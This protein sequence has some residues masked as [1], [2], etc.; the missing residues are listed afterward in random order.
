MDGNKTCQTVANSNTGKR[1]KRKT[2]LKFSEGSLEEYESFKSQFIVHHKMLDW[3]TNRAG[4]ELYVSL[5]GKAALN[6]EEVA[7]NA[8]STS[9]LSG[10]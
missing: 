1:Y 5:Q 6:V 10:M 2:D 4:I 3:D 8:K 9:D 7:M